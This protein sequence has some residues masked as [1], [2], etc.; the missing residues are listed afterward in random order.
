MILQEIA[1]RHGMNYYTLS[2]YSIREIEALLE[3]GKKVSDSLLQKRQDS[4]FCIYSYGEKDSKNYVY[5]KESRKLFDMIMEKSLGEFVCGI[6]ASKSKNRIVSGKVK[7]VVDPK[8]EKFKSSEILVTSMTRVEFVP[9]MRR[10]KA[11]IT[12]EGGMACHAAI[13]SRELG[14]P[15]I[16]GTKNAT[17]ILR[18]GDQ[19]EMD[20]KTGEIKILK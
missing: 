5:G 2:S 10:A 11:I 3:N 1:R 20:M 9:L 15:A 4:T 8:N 12:N 6:V 14:I 13:V 19:V 7:I 18:D 17:R 16:I